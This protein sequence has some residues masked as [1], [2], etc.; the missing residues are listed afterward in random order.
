MQSKIE[1]KYI[2]GNLPQRIDLSKTKK[3][4]ILNVNSLHDINKFIFEYMPDSNHSLIIFRNKLNKYIIRVYRLSKQ[5]L[6]LICSLRE[7][8]LDIEIYCCAS[9]YDDDND[10]NI[11]NLCKILDVKYEQ[12]CDYMNDPNDVLFDIIKGMKNLKKVVVNDFNDTHID[13]YCKRLCDS[14]KHTNITMLNFKHSFYDNIDNVTDIPYLTTLYVNYS[15]DEKIINSMKFN[16]NSISSIELNVLNTDKCL[17]LLNGCMNISK[18][19]HILKK[20]EIYP[21]DG[22]GNDELLKAYRITK[23]IEKLTFAHEA[24]KQKFNIDKLRDC[25]IFC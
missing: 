25:V 16:K 11:L 10:V 15:G 5:S 9:R 12:V 7:N 3:Y 8:I 19:K 1:V 22:E 6:D 2:L 14:L 18:C 20:I 13:N 17:Y 24:F 23:E 4:F 21:S